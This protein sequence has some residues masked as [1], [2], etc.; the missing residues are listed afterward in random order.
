M[1]SMETKIPPAVLTAA[2]ALLMWL[3]PFIAPALW[4][5]LPWQSAVM[6]L[7]T[8]PGMA[9]TLFGAGAF[10]HANTTVDPTRPEMASSLVITGIYRYS[11]NPM[12][13]GFLLVLA[14]WG[15]HISN[16]LAFVALPVYVMYMTRFQILPEERA[17]LARFGAAYSD[18]QRSVRR[19]L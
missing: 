3:T 11:R 16:L 18:Y 17:L 9:I 15:M 7:I 6:W 8:L 13:L 12:Y 2:I 4:F 10:H 5:S 1:K 19:W 14:G